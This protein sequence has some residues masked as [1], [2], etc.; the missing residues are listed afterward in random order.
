MPENSSRSVTG[1]TRVPALLPTGYRLL[2]EPPT[3]EEY[4]QLRRESGLS[5]RTPAQASGALS[6]S[7]AWT[8][9][10]T[11]EGVLAAMGRVI[12][13]GTWYFHL[14]DIATDPS[15]QRRG[16]GRVVM[17]QLIAR[18]DDVA[19]PQPYI[20]LLADPPGQSL[21]RSLGFVDSDPSLGMRLPR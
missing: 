1:P 12:G 2:E 13:D 4:V 16:L 19:P 8:T 20:T 3:S 17:E 14:A 6:A 21:Y 7:W 5:P 10:R 11:A 15:H 9:V 18:I